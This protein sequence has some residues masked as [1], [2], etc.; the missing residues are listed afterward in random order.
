MFLKIMNENI[1]YMAGKSRYK[2]QIIEVMEGG[3]IKTRITKL[4][5]EPFLS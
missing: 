3:G 5:K 4:L 1:S 2:I